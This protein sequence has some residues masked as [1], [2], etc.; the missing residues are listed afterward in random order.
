[1]EFD[2]I[3]KYVMLSTDK[4]K[5]RHNFELGSCLISQP[6]ILELLLKMESAQPTYA[7]GWIHL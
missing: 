6:I 4:L 7:T 3:L 5:L 1:M 2:V